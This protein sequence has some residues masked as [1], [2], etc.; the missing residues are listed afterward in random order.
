VPPRKKDQ[1]HSLVSLCQV[2]ASIKKSPL[3]LRKG[4][5]YPC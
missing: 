3:L 1:P 2:I 5:F 4:I